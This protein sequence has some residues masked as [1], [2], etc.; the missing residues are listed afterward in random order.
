MYGT[1]SVGPEEGDLHFFITEDDVVE[2]LLRRL[3]KEP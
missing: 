3:R 1:R 2:E